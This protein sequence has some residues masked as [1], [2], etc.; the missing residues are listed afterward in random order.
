M[1]AYV[2]PLQVHIQGSTRYYKPQVPCTVIAAKAFDIARTKNI[3]H[4]NKRSNNYKL[5][6]PKLPR[7]NH[8]DDQRIMDVE[9]DPNN[10]VDN[11]IER[12]NKAEGDG[13]VELNQYKDL[14]T[15]NVYQDLSTPNTSRIP[16]TD[17]NKTPVTD[18]CVLEAFLEE[19]DSHNAHNVWWRLLIDKLPPGQF[20]NI[21]VRDTG[22]M[23]QICQ[24]H[25]DTCRHLLFGRP[26]NWRSGK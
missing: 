5:L 3:V 21:T 22:S 11:E 15:G 17:G 19:R 25:V 2:A 18:T 4:D 26:K 14:S 23:C 13:E 8:K 24:V 7:P 9:E 16:P 10:S 6:D 12:N 20:F 1:S